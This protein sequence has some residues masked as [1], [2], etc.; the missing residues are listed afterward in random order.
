MVAAV[1][2]AEA[3]AA[4]CFMASINSS[5]LS[6]LFPYTLTRRITGILQLVSLFEQMGDI[7]SQHWR[8]SMLRRDLH[9]FHLVGRSEAGLQP[10]AGPAGADCQRCKCG[11]LLWDIWGPRVRLS[12]EP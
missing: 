10:A 6:P 4:A 5:K 11:R 3:N 8:G 12:G 2:A 1:V 7:H 9:V